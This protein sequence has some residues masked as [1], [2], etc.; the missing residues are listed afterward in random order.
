MTTTKSH[1]TKAQFDEVKEALSGRYGSAHFLIDG[2]LISACIEQQKR[3]LCI[4]IYVNGWAKGSDAWRGKESQ[5]NEM[6]DIARKFF[7]LSRSSRPAAEI[8]RYEKL[9]GKRRC[10][11]E[12][13]WL[14]DKYCIAWFVFST[15]GAFIAHIKKHNDSIEILT[16]EAYSE[17]LDLLPPTEVK[18]HD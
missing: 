2:Y 8:K 4:A 13:S 7:C 1:P 9:L 18:S 6:P 10:Q 3:K 14:Y 15:A 17:A 12:E 16:T 11:K 5:L